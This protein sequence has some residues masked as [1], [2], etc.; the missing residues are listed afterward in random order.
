M[1]PGIRFAVSKEYEVR[2]LKVVAKGIAEGV[3]S[4]QIKELMVVE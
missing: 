4:D 2:N 3:P 1:G